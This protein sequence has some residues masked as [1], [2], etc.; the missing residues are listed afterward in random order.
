[1]AGIGPYSQQTNYAPWVDPI[2]TNIL[3]A[4]AQYQEQTQEKNLQQI[5]DSYDQILNIPA[6]GKDREVLQQ[7][8]ADLQDQVSQLSYSDLKNPQTTSQLRNL[9]KQTVNDPDIQNI[10]YRGY[11]Y[12]QML[13]EKKDYEKQGK[14]Y[15]NSGL[16]ALQSYYGG[17]DYIRNVNF[18]NDGFTPPDV[19][20]MLKEAK[21]LVGQKERTVQLPNGEYQTEKYTDPDDL[22]KAIDQIRSSNP[23]YQKTDE[24][25][26]N[27]ANANVDWTQQ[28]ADI[29]SSDAQNIT[30]TIDLATKRM[31]L[32]TNPARKAELQDQIN[33]YLSD[34]YKTKKLADNPFYGQALRDQHLKNS[35][36]H[37]NSQIAEALDNA[38]TGD[39]KMDK[40]HEEMLDHANKIAE[41]IAN[42]AY[43]N[44]ADAGDIQGVAAKEDKNGDNES[45]ENV[46]AS[47]QS[48]K[49]F[50]SQPGSTI[51]WSAG[52]STPKTQI[53]GVDGKPT[54]IAPTGVKN[55]G[56]GKISL[57]YD[58]PGL[59]DDQKNKL[60]ES[61]KDANMTITSLFE[62]SGYKYKDSRNHAK[63]MLEQIR[64]ASGN[65]D[66]EKINNYFKVTDSTPDYGAGVQGITNAVEGRPLP[67]KKVTKKD[68]L[69]IL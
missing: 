29:L 50:A 33:G 10:A 5:Q 44:N 11:S 6:Y 41:H 24:Y 36:D 60:E 54:Y 69:G 45:P 21:D 25:N 52:F 61:S 48:L 22:K 66:S 1:M 35:I 40:Y 27:K 18:N 3:M 63:R 47:L 62:P 28:G 67:A 30:R 49:G 34:L 19:A 65:D 39:I 43:D 7:K 31:Q 20:K 38:Q 59:K 4:G 56:N 64:G 37:Q 32:E 23:L 55:L 2:N 17:K 9:I 15:L 8:A 68:P 57:L 42:K 16:D 14:Q 13:Q 46:T 58:V 53:M 12:Q 51:P 26:F